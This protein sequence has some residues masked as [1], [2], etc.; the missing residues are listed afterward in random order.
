MKCPIC[1]Q[2]LCT[3]PNLIEG[4]GFCKVHG[5]PEGLPHW[6]EVQGVKKAEQA[7]VE[8]IEKG[9]K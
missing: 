4:Y 9:T 1:Q 2:P 6:S 5:R 3:E 7:I 8:S